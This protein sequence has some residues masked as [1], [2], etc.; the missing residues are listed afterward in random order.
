MLTCS[1][2]DSETINVIKFV[3]LFIDKASAEKLAEQVNEAVQL[4]TDYNSRLAAEMDDRKK[5][6]SMLQDFIQAQ[7]DLL[8]QAEDRLEVS[9]VKLFNHHE[10]TC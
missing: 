2:D 4:L 10:F 5:L 8:L 1:I 9:N 7:K 6:G 3:Y